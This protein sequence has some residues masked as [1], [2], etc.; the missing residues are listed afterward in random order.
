MNH[1][2]VGVI[3]IMAKYKLRIQARFLRQ[4]GESIRAITQ[5]LGVSKSTVSRWVMDIPLSLKQIEVLRKSSLKG[6]EIGRIKISSNHLRKRQQITLASKKAG[7][8]QLKNFTKRELL[9][10]GIALYWAEG[11]KTNKRIEFCNSDPKM[12]EFVIHWLRVCFKVKKKDL[13]GTVGIHEIHKD[14]EESI[15]AYWSELTGISLAQ[16]WKTRFKKSESKKIY[17]NLN[18]HYGTLSIGVKKSTKLYY[19]MLGLIHGLYGNC[20]RS[21]V[22]EQSFHKR[23]VTGSN[24]VVGTE[25]IVS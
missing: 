6:A 7:E 18:D 21:S 15:K 23:Q 2:Q 11:G 12:I 17:N 25:R 8:M 14:R 20:Q 13:M 9:I 3:Y 22:A 4:Q 16:F 24:P 10:A 19:K 5:L 1:H